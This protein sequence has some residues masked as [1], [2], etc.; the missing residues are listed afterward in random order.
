MPHL[1]R[2]SPGNAVAALQGVYRFLYTSA[3]FWLGVVVLAPVV[4]ILPDFLYR[5]A[6][7]AFRPTE[8]NIFQVGVGLPRAWCPQ[9]CLVEADVGRFAAHD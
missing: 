9:R 6:M 4:A 2:S 5:A 7:L 3:A 8:I 1:L